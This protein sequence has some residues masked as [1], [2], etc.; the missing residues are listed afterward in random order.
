MAYWG[1]L[2]AIS[3]YPAMEKERK[4]AAAKIKELA[5]RASDHEKYYLRAFE[6][7]GQTN[8][9]YIEQAVEKY[10][11]DVDAQAFLGLADSRGYDDQGEANAG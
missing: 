8:A 7:N 11:D 6:N 3:Q 1:I 10:P 5:G 2:Q 4:S 9:N